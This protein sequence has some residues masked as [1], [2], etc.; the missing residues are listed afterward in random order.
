MSGI[1]PPSSFPVACVVLGAGAGTRFGEPKA[2]ALLED[3]V[4]FI[5]AVVATARACGL[6]PV[7]TVVAK[8]LTP[9][10]GDRTVVN[11]NP[12][13]EQIESLRL[14]LAQLVSVN[15]VGAIAWPVDH[16]FVR[17][18]T[19]AAILRIAKERDAPI[20]VP[21]RGGR[22]GHPVYFARDVWR[23]LMTVTA[24]GA[25]TVVQAYASRLA[26][27]PVPDV[28]VLRDIDTREDLIASS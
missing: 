3:G 4:R 16:P 1:S 9:L 28:G 12:L 6:A 10:A 7:V 14:G 25:R 11:P 2:A 15:V 27:V 26:E 8:E 20:V 22:R 23:E 18:D 24:G 19:I 21:T 17:A 13:G 5:D